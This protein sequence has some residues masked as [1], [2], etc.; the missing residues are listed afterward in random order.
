[1]AA[2]KV[3][4]FMTYNEIK[5]DVIVL[6]GGASGCMSAITAARCGAK[7]LLLEQND[8][9]GKKILATGNGKCNYT[10]ADMSIDAFRGNRKMAGNVLQRF[11]RDDTIE[12][13]REAGIW[14]RCKN[15]YYYPNSQTASSVRNAL[16][17][18]LARCGVEVMNNIII[19]DIIQQAG[20]DID[21][22]LD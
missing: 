14:P 13:F 8:R 11:G 9:I 20:A 16:E 2:Q 21:C 19:T 17:A 1:M 18:E 6:G 12:F 15:G 22:L 5:W 7:V 3:T 4:H 10:N